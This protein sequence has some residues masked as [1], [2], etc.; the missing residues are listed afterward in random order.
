MEKGREGI[1][2]STA[3]VVIGMSYAARLNRRTPS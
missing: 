2:P 3:S 1:E